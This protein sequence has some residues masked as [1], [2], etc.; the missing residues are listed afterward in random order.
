M[1]LTIYPGQAQRLAAL[2]RAALVLAALVL[3]ALVLTAQRMAALI[4]AALMPRQQ[5]ERAGRGPLGEAE[6]SRVSQERRRV[7]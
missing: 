4:L 3:T 7:P 6:N 5:K 2:M 1:R